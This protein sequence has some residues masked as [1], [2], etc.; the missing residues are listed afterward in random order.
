MNGGHFEIRCIEQRFEE[1]CVNEALCNNMA[2]LSTAKYTPGVWKNSAMQRVYWGKAADS[3]VQ[4]VER[5]AATKCFIIASRTLATKTDEIQKCEEALGEK[6]AGTWFGMRS[7]SPREDVLSAAAAARAAG[8]DLLISIGGGSVTDGTKAVNLCLDQNITDVEQFDKYLVRKSFF[9]A[10]NWNYKKSV[11]QI[12]I[13][14]T[15]SAG[16]FTFIAGVTNLQ[17][18]VKEAISHPELQP[19]SVILDPELTLHTPEWLWLSTGIRSVDHCA[20][21]IC[22]IN[23]TH[24]STVVASGALRLLAKALPKTKADSNDIDARL[25]CQIGSWQAIQTLLMGVEYGGSH[26]IGHVQGG[27][28]SIPH[29]YTSCINLPYILEYN[30]P[31]IPEKCSIVSECLGAGPDVSAAEAMDALIRGC[32]MPRTLSDVDFP[33]DKFNLVCELSMKDPWTASNP[34]KL[35]SPEDVKIIMTM[36]RDGKPNKEAMM[37]LK[38]KP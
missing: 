17:T 3:L 36:A 8:A 4:E 14:T 24:L 2:M 5:V 18:G 16:E 35:A 10:P 11:L 33:M 32:G 19:I 26:S 1:S 38:G 27:T 30:E 31:E 9:E 15:L 20:E 34:R 12:A 13:P 28:A 21:A 22:S 29:G 23:G 7:H 25:Q 37:R 6:H